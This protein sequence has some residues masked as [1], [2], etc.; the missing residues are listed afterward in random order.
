MNISVDKEKCI[1]TGNCVLA[2][3]EL[4]DQ[5]EDD[6]T[7]IV[8]NDTPAPELQESARHA[9]ATCPALVIQIRE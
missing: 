8:L 9:A 1:S 7:I 2:A 3:A 6:G 4:F 5:N